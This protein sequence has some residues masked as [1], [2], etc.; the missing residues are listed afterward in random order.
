MAEHRLDGVFV[1]A[2]NSTLT[3]QEWSAL[4]PLAYVPL[5]SFSYTRVDCFVTYA[6]VSAEAVLDTGLAG[7]N[8]PFLRGLYGRV[9]RDTDMALLFCACLGDAGAA[10]AWINYHKDVDTQWG[11]MKVHALDEPSRTHFSDYVAHGGIFPVA[12]LRCAFDPN[13]I[14][15]FELDERRFEGD[16]QL[17]FREARSPPS[18]TRP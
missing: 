7:A 8:N 11:F 5:D 17:L 9:F 15:F 2:T 10:L 16:S 18:T 6:R 13:S 3:V 1:R 4:C 12:L 14:W